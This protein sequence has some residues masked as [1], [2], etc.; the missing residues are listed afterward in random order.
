MTIDVAW[1]FIND[2]YNFMLAKPWK[3]LKWNSY[4][5]TAVCKLDVLVG[6]IYIG[7]WVGRELISYVGD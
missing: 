4:L 6:L 2:L 5:C 3:I 1:G 7:T